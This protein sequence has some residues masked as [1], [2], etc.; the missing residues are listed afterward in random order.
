[1]LLQVLGL[2][3]MG[4]F[5]FYAWKDLVQSTSVFKN[6]E[7]SSQ[8]VQELLDALEEAPHDEETKLMILPFIFLV[9]ATI[10]LLLTISFHDGRLL[11][12]SVVA[13]ALESVEVLAICRHQK[14]KQPFKHVVFFQ[15][16]SVL[17]LCLETALFFGMLTLCLI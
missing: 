4:F 6:E 13:L 14:S 2:F 17:A 7:G 3:C 8:Q 16:L 12:M 5:I 11:L 15:R 10:F 1:M 9:Y